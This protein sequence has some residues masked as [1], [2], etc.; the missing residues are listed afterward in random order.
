MFSTL[1]HF[2]KHR[3][4]VPLSF[5]KIGNT[6]PAMRPTASLYHQ[7]L[8]TEIML[9]AKKHSRPDPCTCGLGKFLRSP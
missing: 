8:E 5:I 4:R 6:K 3:Q 1:I 2:I 9:N 7:E